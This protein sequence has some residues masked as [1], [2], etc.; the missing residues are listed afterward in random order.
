MPHVAT[1]IAKR[2]AFRLEA[3][4]LDALQRALN[5]A[6]PVELSPDEAYDFVFDAPTPAGVLAKAG[7]EALPL[8]LVVQPVHGREKRILVADMDSTIIGQE[9]LDEVAAALGLEAKVAPITEAAMQGKLDY[10]ESLRERMA[11]LK[12]TPLATLAKVQTERIRPTAGAR[13]LVSTL[14]AKGAK[15][16]LVSGGLTF[17]VEAIAKDLGFD[18]FLSNRAEAVDGVL[19]GRVFEPVV[20]AAAKLDFLQR[21]AAEFAVPL[22]A[23]AVIGDGANDIPMMQAAGISFAYRG[24]PKVEAAAKARL[25]HASLE[26]VLFACGIPRRDF[27]K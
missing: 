8:D 3:A 10:A 11:I 24:K 5:A 23:A 25:R 26:G 21:L 13:T 18:R 20:G 4:H 2:E 19:T 12:G 16:A 22:E 17:F 1:L 6:P 14:K 9:C 7:L 15:T 27:V